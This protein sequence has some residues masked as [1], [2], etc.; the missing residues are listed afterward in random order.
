MMKNALNSIFLLLALGFL[1]CLASCSAKTQEIKPETRYI[2]LDK[3]AP[4]PPGVIRYCWEE[5]MVE[6]EP[7]GPGLDSDERWYQP[8][9]IAIREVKQGRWR[10]CREM[11]SEI[12]G[13][14]GDER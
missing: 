8:A 9:H 5:P 2:V 10:P 3:A 14:V 11:A 4:V 6:L 1:F 7:I 13:E 12:K